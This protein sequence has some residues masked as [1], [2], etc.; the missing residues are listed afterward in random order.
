MIPTYKY[1]SYKDRCG[2]KK[3]G[4]CGHLLL[5]EGYR[6]MCL[7]YDRIPVT[8]VKKEMVVYAKRLKLCINSNESDLFNIH[9]EI[10]R[11]I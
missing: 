11:Y 10:P 5:E 1:R 3:C 7:K 6:V 2:P 8:I 4:F 9:R